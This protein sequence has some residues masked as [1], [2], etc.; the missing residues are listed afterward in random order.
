MKI[1]KILTFA[2]A[3]ALSFSIF[4]HASTTD[5]VT[6]YA[7]S[8]NIGWISFNNC[9]DSKNATTCTGQ[10][11]G[12]K[13]DPVTGVGSGYAWSSNIGWISFN[14]SE[15]SSNTNC[16]VGTGP[17][18]GPSIIWNPDGPSIIWNPDGSGNMKG[19]VR[20]CSVFLNS[21]TGGCSGPLRLL[22]ETGGWDGFISIGDGVNTNWGGKIA[23]GTGLISGFAWGNEVVGW[24]DL[25]GSGNTKIYFG[26]KPV[27]VVTPFTTNGGNTGSAHYAEIAAK[28]IWTATNSPTSCTVFKNN[29]SLGDFSSPY[30]VP[31]LTVDT[32]YRVDCKN[33]AGTGVG[34][35][36]R[37]T[38]PPPPTN[39]VASCPLP[40][41]MDYL[42]WTLPAS[43]TGTY[44]RSYK[45][46]PSSIDYDAACNPAKNSPDGTCSAI[47]SNTFSMSTTPGSQ[48]YWYLHT[49]ADNG[50]WSVAVPGGTFTCQ[51]PT[52]CTLPQELDSTTNTCFTPPTCTAPQVLSSDR[53]SCV[54]CSAG[55]VYESSSGT[56]I[57]ES[58][59]SSPRIINSS[60]MCV[61][62]IS[63]APQIPSADGMSCVDCPTGKTS[64]YGLTCVD[65][66]KPTIKEF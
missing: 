57:N 58:S 42:D 62:P 39:L 15:V 60:R 50:N 56:C 44:V 22:Y 37:F 31:S 13:F 52:T 59:C 29:V 28:V 51:A 33:S 55:E 49:K 64:T 8:S 4:T 3:L 43:Y 19:F 2:F 40:G 7:W 27:V 12:V 5:N 17:N 11:Y 6:G 61:D 20:A 9:T 45:T 35:T 23:A 21:T 1:L 63:C 24:V 53:K 25:N 30:S 47:N 38:I 54:N 65:K 10:N 18:C 26:E 46:P 32:D 41:T 14:N 34:N 48:Y 16:P 66:K 36:V